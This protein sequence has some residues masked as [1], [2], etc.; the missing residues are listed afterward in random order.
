MHRAAI[1]LTTLGLCA[2]GY[3]LRPAEAASDRASHAQATPAE[4]A[5]ARNAQ[6]RRAPTRIEVRPTRRLYRECVS[7]LAPEARPSGTVITPQ[8]ECHWAVR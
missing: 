3:G 8:M 2:T 7:W 4:V 6:T 1:L 5:A